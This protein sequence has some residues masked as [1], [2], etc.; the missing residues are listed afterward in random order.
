MAR[1][2]ITTFITANM[3]QNDVTDR[4]PAAGV[5][6]MFLAYASIDNAGSAPNSGPS[7]KMDLIDGTNN[8]SRYWENGTTGL[9]VR[10]MYSGKF[11]ADNTNYFRF[12]HLGA[13]TGDYGFAVIVAG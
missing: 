6:E 13:S 2:D 10:I 4:Q 11:M 5:E 9:A 8:E 1:G 7:A 12:T 3:A